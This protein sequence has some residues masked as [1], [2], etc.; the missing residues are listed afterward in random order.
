MR[1]CPKQFLA[2]KLVFFRN[3]IFSFENVKDF[4]QEVIAILFYTLYVSQQRENAL[5]INAFSRHLKE[6]IFSSETFFKL[7]CLLN[8]HLMT[9]DAE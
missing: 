5:V 4:Y 2:I 9:G 7:P 8:A 3:P 1:T 6:T